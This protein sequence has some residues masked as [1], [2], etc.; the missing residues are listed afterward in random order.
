MGM[1]AE[2]LQA[3]TANLMPPFAVVDLDALD[4]NAKSMITRAHGLPI[5]LA[6]KLRRCRA[7]T[8]GCSSE[9][10]SLGR[11]GALACRGNPAQTLKNS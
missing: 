5:R 11:I 8:N 1:V 6:T 3:A 9:A 2:R 7:A 10:S 4:D